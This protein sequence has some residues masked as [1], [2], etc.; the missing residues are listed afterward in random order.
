MK[1]NEKDK[2]KDEKDA[3]LKIKNYDEHFWKMKKMLFNQWII[4]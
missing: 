1:I 3:I 4:T 2:F